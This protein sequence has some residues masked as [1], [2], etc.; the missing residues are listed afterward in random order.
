M[1]TERGKNRMTYEPKTIKVNLDGGKGIGPFKKSEYA[2]FFQELLH[3]TQKAANLVSRQHLVIPEGQ[4]PPTLVIEE[5]GEAKVV[6]AKSFDIDLTAVDWTTLYDVMIM[7][8]VKEWSFGPVD[9]ATLD[10]L[11]ESIRGRLVKE[12]DALY[13][14]SVPLAK[15][16]VGN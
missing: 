15:G 16:G 1:K 14:N 13:G 8:Q 3:G 7:G 6:G 12:V 11:P 10:G 5:G 9:Q 2:V 4:K